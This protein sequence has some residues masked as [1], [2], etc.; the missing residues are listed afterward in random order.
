M[1]QRPR[2]TV[3]RYGSAVLAIAVATLLRFWLD[4]LLEGAGFAVFFVAVVIAGWF[5]GLGPSL[6]ALT[7]SLVASAWLFTAPN[8]QPE[9]L[10][11][12]LFGVAT[13]FFVGVTTALLS[14]SMRSAQRRA[15]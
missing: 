7:L 8:Q 15:E 3:T 10:A 1:V 5:G 13:F 11:R 12:V 9:P 6:L 2:S 4:S 14:E